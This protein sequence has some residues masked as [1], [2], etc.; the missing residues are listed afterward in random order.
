MSCPIFNSQY[1]V[2][3]LVPM[4]IIQLT[5]FS[6]EKLSQSLHHF[7]CSGVKLALF[8][9]AIIEQGIEAPRVCILCMCLVKMMKLVRKLFKR[10]V[11]QFLAGIQS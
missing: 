7:H 10:H 6:M 1:H 8:D 11:L 5:V 4:D 2:L 3:R 9:E